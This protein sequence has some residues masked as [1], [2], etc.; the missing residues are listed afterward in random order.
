MLECRDSTHKELCV[1]ECTSG[2]RLPWTQVSS[3]LH[4]YNFRRPLASPG[5]FLGVRA[6]TTA[7]MQNVPL[8]EYPKGEA[9]IQSRNM[10][11]FEDD[12]DVQ[13][14][15]GKNYDPTYDQ[16]DMR[17]LGKRQELKVRI[18]YDRREKI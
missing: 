1:P 4:S 18:Q 10:D 11:D 7:T 6:A 14:V 13:Q 2:R 8:D 5:I 9:A 15:T 16:R 12:S 17:R 3:V